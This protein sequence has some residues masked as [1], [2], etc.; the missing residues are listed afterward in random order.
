MYAVQFFERAEAD[1]GFVVPCRPEGDASCRKA[2][3]I[4]CKGV[5][6]HYAL[7]LSQVMVQ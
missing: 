1:Q 3:R 2:G 7:Q 4:E 5:I 6:G